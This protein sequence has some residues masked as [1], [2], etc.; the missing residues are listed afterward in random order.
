MK[1]MDTYDYMFLQQLWTTKIQTYFHKH[2]HSQNCLKF[3]S[4]IGIFDIERFL[5]KRTK[6]S[7]EITYFDFLANLT[8]I[9][10]AEKNASTQVRFNMKSQTKR[11]SN[12]SQNGQPIE[13]PC[14]SERRIEKNQNKEIPLQVFLFDLSFFLQCYSYQQSLRPACEKEKIGCVFPQIAS[15]LFLGS[16]QKKQSFNFY[17]LLLI[18]QILLNLGDCDIPAFA[19]QI[20][21]QYQQ[22]SQ[23][24]PKYSSKIP[25]VQQSLRHLMIYCRRGC[26]RS[27]PI[28]SFS[29]TRVSSIIKLH[30]SQ[31]PKVFPQCT[32]MLTIDIFVVKK[33]QDCLQIHRN[34]AHPL[35]SLLRI[36]A[37]ISLI[38]CLACPR[39]FQKKIQQKLQFSQQKTHKW[40]ICFIRHSFRQDQQI[41]VLQNRLDL[42]LS[43]L[44]FKSLLFNIR[45]L[46]TLELSTQD[47]PYKNE[48]L[49]QKT[50]QQQDIASQRQNVREQPYD[51]KLS[52]QDDPYKNEILKLKNTQ[53]PR[54]I[55]QRYESMASLTLEKQNYL[56]KQEQI[57][58]IFSAHFQQNNQNKNPLIIPK[59]DLAGVINS[60]ASGNSEYNLIPIKECFNCSFVAIYDCLL[61]AFQC[62]LKKAELLLLTERLKVPFRKDKRRYRINMHHQNRVKKKVTSTIKYQNPL[63]ECKIIELTKDI[64][65]NP[66]KQQL[67]IKLLLKRGKPKRSH[68]WI[69]TM[70]DKGDNMQCAMKVVQVSITHPLSQSSKNAKRASRIRSAGAQVEVGQASRMIKGG[71]SLIHSSLFTQILHPCRITIIIYLLIDANCLTIDYQSVSNHTVC[72]LS[73]L[74]HL[75]SFIVNFLVET[76]QLFSSIHFLNFIFFSSTIKLLLQLKEAKLSLYLPN[77]ISGQLKQR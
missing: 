5:V 71:Q 13:F 33:I 20:S 15:F 69:T 28:M 11:S 46:S 25:L 62:E 21:K 63:R 14:D 58:Q 32:E 51:S 37:I 41:Q 36:I 4:K 38:Y 26:I 1:V 52:T 73:I 43:V 72:D 8:E 64:Q 75:L 7:K 9:K 3:E 66:I 2:I 34:V 54:I 44:A 56:K 6:K 16:P 65:F 18:S 31:S 49:K 48:I 68:T 53:Q 17:K 47:D 19:M 23:I 76:S 77:H 67:R 10:L 61:M 12:F 39:N 42:G 40:L 50:T 57:S 27:D 60:T 74:L 59:E 35:H 55:G 30:H 29:N 24:S 45:G 22:P 70:P